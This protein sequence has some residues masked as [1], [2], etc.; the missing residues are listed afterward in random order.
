LKSVHRVR[1]VPFASLLPTS[2]HNWPA[3]DDES[4]VSFLFSLIALSLVRS[5]SP[6]PS[7]VETSSASAAGIIIMEQKEG[8]RERER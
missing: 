6:H 8:E 1:T 5:S 2:S 3:P 4:G 7:S